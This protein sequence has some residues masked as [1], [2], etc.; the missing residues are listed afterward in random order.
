MSSSDIDLS[1]DFIF[2]FIEIYFLLKNLALRIYLEYILIKNSVQF[3]LN[4]SNKIVNNNLSRNKQ[5]N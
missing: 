4:N 1:W 5:F 2:G 3:L